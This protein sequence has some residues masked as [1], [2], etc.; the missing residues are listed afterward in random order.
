M[1]QQFSTV[2]KCAHMRSSETREEDIIRLHNLGYSKTKIQTITGIRYPRIKDTI[3]YYL[4]YNSI[5]APAVNG[6]PK[7]SNFIL[8]QIALLTIQ[9]WMTTCLEISNKLFRDHGIYYSKSSIHRQLR[10][11]QYQYR[12][13]KVRQ[14]LTQDHICKRLQFGYSML[15]SIYLLLWSIEP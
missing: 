5:P 15:K 11:M 2:N 1:I 13:S 4:A 10:A 3:N 9:N 6:R 8:T 12:Q 7:P 14:L